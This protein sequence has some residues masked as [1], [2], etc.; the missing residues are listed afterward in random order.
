LRSDLLLA[1]VN[2]FRPGV[3][4]VDKHPFGA[5]GEFKAGLK[6]LR[7]QGGRAVLGLRDILD[8]P[9][10]VLKEWAPYRMQRR[11]AKYFHR[12][13]IYGERAVFDP[14]SAYGFP[15]GLAAITKFC[16]YVFVRPDGGPLENFAPPFPSRAKRKRAV[17]MATV[18][19]GEDGYRTLGSFI[20]AARGAAWQGSR[21][22]GL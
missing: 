15:P 11:I 6:A 17:V 14:V 4:L 22:R 5:S 8:E 9:A 12:V 20:Q 13:L 18:G 19:G 7:K 10:Q 3:V 1:A 2:S 21:W 16:G